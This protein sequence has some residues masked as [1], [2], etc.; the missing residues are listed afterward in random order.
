M[1]SPHSLLYR[2][3]QDLIYSFVVSHK[4]LFIFVLIKPYSS[5]MGK[6]S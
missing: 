1:K 6:S 5:A 3:S 2:F 4:I